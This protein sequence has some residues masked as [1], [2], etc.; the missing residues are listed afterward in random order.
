MKNPGRAR[1][2]PILNIIVD[3]FFVVS[4]H[5]VLDTGIHKSLSFKM[6]PELMSENRFR[7]IKSTPRILT[8][9]FFLL[10]I[11][12]EG[13]KLGFGN[14]WDFLCVQ[15]IDFFFFGTF[16]RLPSYACAFLFR[17]SCDI[18]LNRIP[19]ITSICKSRK[20]VSNIPEGL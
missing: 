11:K 8:V 2:L 5:E 20:P 13:P 17:F 10:K 6:I 12:V 14:D 7:S 3:I 18:L 15:V 19:E 9:K 1:W 16:K 4:A